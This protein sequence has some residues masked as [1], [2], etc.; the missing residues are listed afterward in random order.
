MLGFSEDNMDWLYHQALEMMGLAFDAL[1]RKVGNPERQ[2]MGNG[3]VYRYKEKSIYQA[4]VQKLAIVVTGLQAISLMNKAGLLQEQAALQ[5]TLDEI[6]EDIFFLCFG[7]IFSEI[8]DLHKNYLAA[9]YEEEFDNPESAIASTQKRPMILRQKIRAFISRDRGAGY[10]QS[11]TIEVL[12]TISKTYSGYVHG[13]SPQLMELYYGDPPLFHL[14]GGTD[15]P[16]YEDH[17]SD[18]LNYY[19]RAIHSFAFAAKAFGE[20]ALFKKLRDFSGKFAV[21]S[22][23]ENQLRG[24]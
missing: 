19:Y 12:R 18:L 10:D 23:H 4:I 16:F 9:F 11:S 14:S 17:M 3:Y 13:A 8:T 1:S 20:E 5:R 24:Q 22:G 6:K 2:P 15:S 7:I 21:A